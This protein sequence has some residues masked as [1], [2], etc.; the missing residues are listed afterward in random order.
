MDSKSHEMLPAELLT[1][2][3]PSLPSTLRS[4]NLKGSK[5]DSSHIPLL[6]PLSKHLEELG[7]GRHINLSDIT[8][9]FAPSQSLSLQQQ[10]AWEPHTL[11]YIDISDLSSTSLDL[12]SLFSSSCPILKSVSAPL[13]VLEISQDVLERVQRSNVLERVGWCVKE[14]GRRAWFVRVKGSEAQKDDGSRSWK[15][16]ACYW[17]M[18][19]IPVARAE[20]GG[21]YGHYMFKR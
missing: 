10:L 6:L 9:F 21:M 11:H 15:W 17:G 16:G 14:A 20:V 5:M 1:E 12:P 13:E 7:L 19:K 4:L 2:L 18:R 8:S 3:I